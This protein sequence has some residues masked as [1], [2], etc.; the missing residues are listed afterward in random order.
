[1]S[2]SFTTYSMTASI[3][4]YQTVY[5]EVASCMDNNH[6]V[7]IAWIKSTGTSVDMQLMYTLFN[8]QTKNFSTQQIT[9]SDMSQIKQSPYIITDANNNP[10][11]VFFAKRDKAGTNATGN[12][13]VIYAGDSNGDGVFEVSQVSP[14]PINPV[15][16]TKSLE[17]CWVNGRPNIYLTASGGIE[18]EYYGSGEDGAACFQCYHSVKATKSG[19]NWIRGLQWKEYTL[20]GCCSRYTTTS[21][22]SFPNAEESNDLHGFIFS[23]TDPAFAYKSGNTWYMTKIVEYHSTNYENDNI[24]IVKSNDGVVHYLWEYNGL[25]NDKFCHTTITGSSYSAIDT[26]R[27]QNSP[28]GNLYGSTV[29]L[30]TGNQVYLYGKS[31]STD[32]YIINNNLET[33]ITAVGEI[34][35]RQSIHA[36]NGFIAAVTANE[37]TDKLFVTI[38]GS[39]VGV[40]DISKNENF[41]ISQDSQNGLLRI[42][43]ANKTK[44]FVQL[45]S[46]DGKILKSGDLNPTDYLEFNLSDSNSLIYIVKISDGNTV[47]TKKIIMQ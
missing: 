41:T 40:N 20:L 44:Y 13:A 17:N 24:K 35:G 12:Y 33:K 43:S 36:D 23:H 38:S 19:S 25:N 4:G 16:D 34:M 10:H 27:L 9:I 2:Q 21:G 1:M 5:A 14:N 7:H 39:D 45:I 6:N 22:S 31:S 47:Y 26:T 15:T 42:T 11:I 18:V 30:T 37:S 46:I 29:D 8:V 28:A 32:C 3:Y